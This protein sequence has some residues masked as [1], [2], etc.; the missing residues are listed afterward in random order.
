MRIHKSVLFLHV[1]AVLVPLGAVLPPPA[2]GV[3]QEFI[4]TTVAGGIS[5]DG[6]PANQTQL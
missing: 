2:Q 3:A 5:G 4:I 6:V 1:L